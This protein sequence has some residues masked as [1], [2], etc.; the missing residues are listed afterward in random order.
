VKEIT[1]G[2]PTRVEEKDMDFKPRVPKLNKPHTLMTISDNFIILFALTCAIVL[3]L[4]GIKNDGE[5][6]IV[7]ALISFATTAFSR[8]VV[9]KDGE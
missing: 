4:H 6:G 8:D 3:V 2:S 1:S 9:N 5:L 7:T